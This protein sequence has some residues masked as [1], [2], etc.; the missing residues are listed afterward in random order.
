MPPKTKTR[1]NKRPK[2]SRDWKEPFST[3]KF[4]EDS[5]NIYEVSEIEEEEKVEQV[6]KPNKKS[7]NSIKNLIIDPIAEISHDYSSGEEAKS[8][9]IQT[10]K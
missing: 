3:R 9:Y 6:Y 8:F 7:E 2:I 5:R 1:A 10:K 4:K